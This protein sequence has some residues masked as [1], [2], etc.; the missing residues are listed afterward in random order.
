MKQEQ[1][2]GGWWEEDGGRGGLDF[3]FSTGGQSFFGSVTFGVT[4]SCQQANPRPCG[5]HMC[6]YTLVH[7]IWPVYSRS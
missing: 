7:N 2:E 1:G 3:I 4:G 5:T 6:K